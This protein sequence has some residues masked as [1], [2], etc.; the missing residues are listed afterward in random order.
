MARAWAGGWLGLNWGDGGCVKEI[1]GNRLEL[2][3]GVRLGLGL[4]FG[5]GVEMGLWLG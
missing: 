3:L 5:F 1:K 4:G 2:G